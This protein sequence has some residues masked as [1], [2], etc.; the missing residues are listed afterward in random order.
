MS[1]HPAQYDGRRRRRTLSALADQPAVLPPPDELLDEPPDE[2]LPDELLPDEL[3]LDELPPDELEPPLEDELAGAAA[4]FEP[5]DSV[6]AAAFF[7]PPLSPADF[8]D[9][10]AGAVALAAARE[11]VR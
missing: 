5:A 2:L 3:L 1:G 6:D 11:S 8:S 9:P 10:F 4:G 7:S